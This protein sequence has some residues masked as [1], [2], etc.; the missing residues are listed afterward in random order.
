MVPGGLRTGEPTDTGSPGAGSQESCWLKAAGGPR[1]AQSCWGE[2]KFRVRK[3]VCE[4][5]CK[6]QEEMKTDSEG[7][8]GC[9]AV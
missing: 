8:P 4:D 5:K 3:A 2:E 7:S 1:E 9:S 6:G